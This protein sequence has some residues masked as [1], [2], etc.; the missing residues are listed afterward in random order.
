MFSNITE[1]NF[2]ELKEME[3][4]YKIQNPRGGNSI[5]RIRL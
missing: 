5:E 1:K 2:L 4:K 3:Q